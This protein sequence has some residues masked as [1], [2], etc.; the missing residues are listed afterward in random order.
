M[1]YI[2]SWKPL[3]EDL[4]RTLGPA[5]TQDLVQEMETPSQGLSEEE[6]RMA[7]ITQGVPA[8][9]ESAGEG[10]AMLDELTPMFEA[11]SDHLSDEDFIDPLSAE[12]QEEDNEES[13]ERYLQTR[14]TWSPS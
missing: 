8:G 12:A 7:F 5:L 4:D 1:E 3:K 6:Q 2:S 10:S 13:P 11:L 9:L 14:S